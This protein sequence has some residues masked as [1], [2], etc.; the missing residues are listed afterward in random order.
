MNASNTFE[1]SFLKLLF[2]NIAIAGIG[3]A[4]GLLAAAA[5]GN[6][7]IRLCTSASVTDDANIGTECAYTGY[8]AKGIAAVRSAE[9]WTVTDNEVVN[10]AELTFGA[11]TAGAETI[12]YVEVWK[13]NTGD[14]E[15]DRIAWVQLTAD[16]AIS[17]GITPKF[18]AEALTFTFD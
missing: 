3:N 1:N 11:C 8:V 10:A 5:A 14:A 6:L 2:Q 9:G 16:L 18:V 15:A 17:A 7:Y 13:N 4:G 12:R